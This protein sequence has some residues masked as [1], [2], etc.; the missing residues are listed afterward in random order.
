M[1]FFKK[2]FGTG[3]GAA[4]GFLAGGPIGAL[5]G[6][7]VGGTQQRAGEKA[8][9]AQD[10]YVRQ[11]QEQLSRAEQKVADQESRQRDIIRQRR[12]GEYRGIGKSGMFL[13]TPYTGSRVEGR[14]DRTTLG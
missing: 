12:I 9:K 8:K 10:Q 2:F 5:L 7:V 1:G 6:G 14:G 3:I 11:Q 4:L 13:S